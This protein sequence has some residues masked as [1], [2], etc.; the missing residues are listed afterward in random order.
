MARKYDPEG[1][2]TIGVLTKVDKH[3]GEASQMSN[4]RN[5]QKER[6]RELFENIDRNRWLNKGYIM[7]S[8]SHACNLDMM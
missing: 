7:V 1:I 8:S 3:A 2:R 6:L 4:V 5:P